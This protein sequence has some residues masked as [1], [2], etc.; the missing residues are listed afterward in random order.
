[1]D[2]GPP[3]CQDQDCLSLNLELKEESREKKGSWEG[4]G[5]ACVGVEGTAPAAQERC[6]KPDLR[7]LRTRGLR[8]PRSP[9]PECVEGSP[10]Y[11]IR[12]TL[13]LQEW[14]TKGW[15][16]ESPVGGAVVAG[17]ECVRKETSL[18]Q[19]QDRL[20]RSSGQALASQATETFRSSPPFLP[21]WASDTWQ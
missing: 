5:P 1:M 15:S 17:G 21:P 10:P 3:Q 16:M 11:Q 4:P 7:A 2:R 14:L 13:D 12:C 9:R 8:V 18:Q 20:G 19:V 6:A